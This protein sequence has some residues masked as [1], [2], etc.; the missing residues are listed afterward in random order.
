MRAK[1]GKDVGAKSKKNVQ[2]AAKVFEQYGDEIHAM[3][4][5][6]IN[7]ESRMDDIFQN[8]F[9][10]LVRNPIPAGISNVKGYLYRAVKNDVI[11]A[12]RRT[13]SHENCIR[14]YAERQGDV[15]V[16]AH[17][18]PDSH[19]VEFEEIV[20]LC[21]LIAEAL[22]PSEAKAVILTCRD[23]LSMTEAGDEMGV[24]ARSVSRYKC[25]GLR[26]AREVLRDK[27][28]YRQYFEKGKKDDTASL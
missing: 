3:I 21:W 17:R 14:K 28:E 5:F 20:N 26:K 18:S 10:S 16:A 8:L 25:L 11:D 27:E 1:G 24:N 23:D 15:E 19:A 2:R 6:Q 9:V 12:S 22:P 4:K 13:R 7:D